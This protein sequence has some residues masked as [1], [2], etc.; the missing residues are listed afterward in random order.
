MNT[1]E[2]FFVKIVSVV[3]KITIK[4]GNKEHNQ[5]LDFILV[6]SFDLFRKYGV[7]SISMDD[8]A[9]E[10]GMSKKTLYLYVDNKTDLIR[11]GFLQAQ[12][13]FRKSIEKVCSTEMNAIDELLA[14]SKL[15]NEEI[16]K[17]NPSNT[18]DLKK[19]YHEVFEEHVN[20]DKAFS[21]RMIV[22]NLRKGIEEKIYRDDLDVELV[23]GLYIQKVES[24]HN[25]KILADCNP[26]MDRIFEVMFENHIRGIANA[27]GIAYFEKRKQQLNFK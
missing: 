14:F 23:A 7:R 2:T 9:R 27:N 1:A 4:L 26:S 11:K 24:M 20:G 6:R 21:Y 22:K 13:D 19:Y 5:K 25:E 15:V 16:K 8:I 17:Y 10:L 3:F 12:A 18:F